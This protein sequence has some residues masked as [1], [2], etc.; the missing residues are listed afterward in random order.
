MS[1][2]KG[3]KETNQMN[4][5]VD[6]EKRSRALREAFEEERDESLRQLTDTY[7]SMFGRIGFAKWSTMTLP[8]LILNPYHVPPYP[9]RQQWFQQL[10]NVSFPCPVSEVYPTF[11]IGPSLTT[12]HVLCFDRS[13]ELL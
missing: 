11:F 3:I 5:S 8:V 9:V 6:P 2:K 12:F 13:D 10:D 4:E 7:K 1:K